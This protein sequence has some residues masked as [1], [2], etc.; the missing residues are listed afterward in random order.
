MVRSKRTP[1]GPKDVVVLWAAPSMALN[2]EIVI[3][4]GWRNC[5]GTKHKHWERSGTP[6]DKRS[7][8]SF[9]SMCLASVE[10][11]VCL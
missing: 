9:L 2:P 10:S 5:H 3:L 7:L 4:L 11:Y 8:C 1:T 6:Q